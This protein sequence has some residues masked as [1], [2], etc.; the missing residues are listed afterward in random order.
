MSMD[1]SKVRDEALRMPS[2][3]RARLATELLQSLDDSGDE[4]DPADHE[5]AW[6]A[7]IAERLRQV[8][9]GEVQ[10]VPW[11]EARRRIVRED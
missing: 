8:D 10:A 11:T 2:E 1:P 4:L 5:L 7:E 3:A 6:S 9:A